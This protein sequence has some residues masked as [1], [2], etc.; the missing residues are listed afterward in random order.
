MERVLTETNVIE[1][2]TADY[3][4][5]EPDSPWNPYLSTVIEQIL[6]YRKNIF[7]ETCSE[8]A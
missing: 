5:F 7:P 4:S 3:F 6:M 1:R 8:G 2:F